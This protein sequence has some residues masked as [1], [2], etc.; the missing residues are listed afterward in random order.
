V[1]ESENRN[2]YHGAKVDEK[3]VA[4]THLRMSHL[5]GMRKEI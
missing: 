4:I 1:L 5:H 2:I 3:L